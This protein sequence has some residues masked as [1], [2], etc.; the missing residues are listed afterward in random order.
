[1]AHIDNLNAGETDPGRSLGLKRD[2]VLKVDDI[3]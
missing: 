3:P 1:M 2:P